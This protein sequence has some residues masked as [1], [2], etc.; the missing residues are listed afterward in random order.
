MLLVGLGFLERMFFISLS[1]SLSWAFVSIP[2]ARLPC[3]PVGRQTTH[4]THT[5]RAVGEA[6]GRVGPGKCDPNATPRGPTERRIV[7]EGQ[8]LGREAENPNNDWRRPSQRKVPGLPFRE[9]GLTKARAALVPWAG[10]AGKLCPPKVGPTT[11]LLC[12]AISKNLLHGAV[13][14][15]HEC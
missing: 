14:R 4:N 8:P 2:L 12:A 3:S 15:T 11:S 9:F 5:S 13:G 7:E 1:S 10:D 6:C